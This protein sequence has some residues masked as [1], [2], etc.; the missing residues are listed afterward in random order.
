MQGRIQRGTNSYY[1]LGRVTLFNIAPLQNG[2][3]NKRSVLDE[4]LSWQTVEKA[5]MRD[6]YEALEAADKVDVAHNAAISVTLELRQ[7]AGRITS[8]IKRT[9]SA[10][11]ANY[12]CAWI[13]SLKL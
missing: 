6:I 8:G 13:L 12:C 7:A 4:W 5:N 1:A 10:L 9:Q 2:Y 11:K 3:I